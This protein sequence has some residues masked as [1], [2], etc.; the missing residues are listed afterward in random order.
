M[1]IYIDN[2]SRLKQILTFYLLSVRGKLLYTVCLE[3]RC[4][5]VVCG[6]LKNEFCIYSN[7]FYIKEMSRVLY[8]VIKWLAQI[9]FKIYVNLFFVIEII[10]SLQL[11]WS[12]SE[13][14]NWYEM[15][16]D[17]KM[18]IQMAK[19]LLSI[20]NFLNQEW[21]NSRSFYGN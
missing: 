2:K 16:R 18:K 8:H 9:H 1:G 7:S 21:K 17:F 19:A 5:L 14:L 4:I 20:W 11:T 15:K 12:P 10:I 6:F 13:K 3:T